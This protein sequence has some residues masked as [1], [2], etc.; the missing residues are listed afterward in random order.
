MAKIVLNNVQ[1]RYGKHLVL[2]EVNF[3]VN[4][5]ELCVITGPSGCG[6]TTILRVIAGL[7]RPEKGEVYFDSQPATSLSPGERDVAMCFQTFALYPH[8]TV[9]E[10]WRF[11]L[12]AENL[13]PQAVQERIEDITRLLRMELLLH[14]YP[15]QLSG[16]QQQR[17]ALGRALVRRP[18]AYLL[19]E[20]LGNLDAKLRVEMR[21]EIRK[22][23]EQLKIT[24]VYVTHDQTEAQAVAHRLVVMDFGVVRQVGTPEE[25]YEKP[26]N[27]FVAGFIGTPR[28]NFFP[29]TVREENGQLKLL[30]PLFTLTPQQS[31]QE[32]LRRGPREI[33]LGIR[34]ENVALS[35]LPSEEAFPA[36][37]EVVEPQ[38]SELIVTLSAEGYS[39]K[40]RTKR[41]NLPHTPEI[42]ERMWVR[43]E[44]EALHFFSR[45]KEHRIN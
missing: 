41:R 24:T 42:G 22:I 5:G 40:S 12:D 29:A 4:D 17:V 27:L 38:S 11:P 37:V 39:F 18:R 34:P 36:Q 33:I 14:R 32:A 25:V 44:K 31:D 45:E 6:K 9:E 43:F 20:P 35:P 10:N 15:R 7:T 3:T 21:A 16:G 13:S 1:V 8:M 28:M 30:N 26:A 2:R 19:D 23:Q